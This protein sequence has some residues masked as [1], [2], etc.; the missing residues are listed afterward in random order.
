M[1]GGVRGGGE[2]VYGV[3]VKRGQLPYTP[4]TFTATLPGTNP[5]RAR[6]ARTLQHCR[7]GAPILGP[8]Q[9]RGAWLVQLR[10][11]VGERV[12]QLVDARGA[13]PVDQVVHVLL[14]RGVLVLLLI[15]RG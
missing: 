1:R 3:G 10:H 7:L 4:I 8:G 2:R 11:F 9:G 5:S 13:P 15:L 14:L 12:D 6:E